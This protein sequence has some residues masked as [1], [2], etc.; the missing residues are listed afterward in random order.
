MKYTKISC[1]PTPAVAQQDETVNAEHLLDLIKDHKK[2]KDML[3]R[4]GEALRASEQN[5]LSIFES[6]ANLIA[7]IDKKGIIIDC[8]GKIREVLGYEKDE[9]IGKSS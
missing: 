1:I 2:L 5:Y 8:N 6:V 7:T 9:I 4:G 3:K